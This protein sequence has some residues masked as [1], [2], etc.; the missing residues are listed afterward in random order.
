MLEKVKE[1]DSFYRQVQANFFNKKN[2]F[3]AY[4][5]E[6]NDV[7][8][9]E[10]VV[11][12]LV[13]YIG[14]KNISAIFRNFLKDFYSLNPQEILKKY[15]NISISEYNCLACLL[16][17]YVGA[18]I[19]CQNEEINYVADC[20]RYGKM[21]KEQQKLLLLWQQLFQENNINLLRPVLE[22]ND[23]YE[24]INDILLRGLVPSNNEIH[25]LLEMPLNA[26]T[27]DETIFNIYQ[28]ILEEKV[29]TLTK[30]YK[31]VEFSDTY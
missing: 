24:I 17:T 22:Y 23:D 7:E 20:S 27:G 31:N 1:Y 15:G 9:Y 26:Q 2:F 12:D 25:C 21:T 14:V 16:T 29:L 8:D 30:K 5:I 28:S 11:D 10:K 3:H 13:K 18:L 19:V 4:I 6:V